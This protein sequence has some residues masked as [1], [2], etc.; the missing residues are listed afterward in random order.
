M[1]NHD[2]IVVGASRGGV[3]ALSKIASYFE[4][5]FPAAVFVVQHTSPRRN[6]EL[7]RILSRAGPLKACYPKN[8]EKWLPGNIYIAPANH[9][10]LVKGDRIAL[11]MGPR[12][13]RMRPSI[14]VLFRSAAA[15]HGTRAVAVLLTGYLDDGVSGLFAVKR[16]GGI[17]IVQDPAEAHTPELPQTAIDTVE[18]DH[19]LPLKS[20]SEEIGR[21][22]AQ[23]AEVSFST[24]Q[25]I[26]DEVRISEHNVPDV[27]ELEKIGRLTPLTCP[28]C[29]GVLWQSENEPLLRLRCH[30]GHA[31][32][33]KSYL[34]GQSEIIEYSLWAAVQHLQERTKLLRKMAEKER[35]KGHLHI[36]EDYEKKARDLGYHADVIRNFITEETLAI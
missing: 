10:L 30:T 4:K 29:G 7:N 20:I 6:S 33:A 34:D 19:V 3:G 18:V 26:L 9:H 36:A 1:A 11:T 21:L 2:I 24:P 31:F 28:E 25:D 8:D 27:D 32:S 16:C 23:P 17:T 35:E 5:D 22:A 15:S 12:E 14:D 13:N